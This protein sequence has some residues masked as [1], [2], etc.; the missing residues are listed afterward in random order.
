MDGRDLFA[1]AK[2]FADLVDISRS[3]GH[4]LL[5]MEFGRG[6]QEEPFVPGIGADQTGAEILNGGLGD[7]MGG[8]KGGVHLEK[9]PVV[10][11]GSYAAVEGASF[12]LGFEI[13][14]PN[15]RRRREKRE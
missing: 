5:H 12:A 13:H 14:V 15:D 6:D 4:Q 7:E 2:A 10:E 9:I 3:G 11:E 1:V 8:E